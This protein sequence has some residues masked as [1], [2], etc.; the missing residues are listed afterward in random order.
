MITYVLIRQ[1]LL[2]ASITAI[3]ETNNIIIEPGL[4]E[5]TPFVALAYR[6]NGA[7]VFPTR[8]QSLFGVQQVTLI[9]SNPH[10]LKKER[11]LAPFV[12]SILTCLEINGR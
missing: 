6:F 5:M 4:L 12:Y 9:H 7:F 3:E 2:G 1:N 10:R 11:E 8:L